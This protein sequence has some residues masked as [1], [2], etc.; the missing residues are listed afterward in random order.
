M[1]S[2][3]FFVYSLLLLFTPASAALG[4]GVDLRILP[5]GDS[6]T[7]GFKSSDGNGYRNDLLSK[8][9]G[10]NVRYIGSQRA[11][12]MANNQNDGYSGF[13]ISQ[14]ASQI[15]PA[16][17]QRPN[18]VLLMAGT[19]DINN[20]DNTGTAPNRLG[21]LLDQIISTCPDA[22]V[23]LA[24][25]TPIADG[26]AESRAR[27]FNSAIDTVAQS[28]INAGHKVV[29]VDMQNSRNGLTAGDLTDGLHP[30]NAGYAKMANVWWDGL[31][32]ASSKNLITAPVKGASL[33]GEAQCHGNLFWY[34]N[35]GTIA[36]GVGSSD[37]PFKSLWQPVGTVATGIGPGPGVRIADMDGDGIDDYVMV[38]AKTGAAELYINGGYSNG[39]INWISEGQIASGIGDGAGVRFADI[40]GDGKA[41]Y[42]WIGKDGSLTAYENGGPKSGGG[43]N[44]RPLNSITKG[45]DTGNRNSI[46]FA[47]L[48]GDGRA[49]FSI[50]GSGGSLKSWIATGR[51]PEP[52]WLPLGQTASGI[53]DLAGV[54][55]VDLNGDGRAD[56]VWLD[57]NSASY[58]YMNLRAKD[59]LVPSW[60]NAGQIGSG[61]GTGRE[62]ITFGDLT[63]DGKADFLVI[64]NGTGAIDMYVNN[65]KG[66]SYQAGDQVVFAD[67]D[68]D[69]LD[70]YISIGPNG[71]LLAY[72]NGGANSAAHNGWN[73]IN[74]GTIASG[75]AKREQIRYV[76]HPKAMKCIDLSI[77]IGRSQ[78]RW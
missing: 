33:G 31:N 2:L 20:N 73:W 40:T 62:N 63:G 28:R 21:A 32:I 44:F 59:S 19:N 13:E 46:I 78:W 52:K 77:Q 70:D 51:D 39:K 7:Y 53:G 74:W 17:S 15:A 5:V 61:V 42:I 4:N 18:I 69:G 16:L 8:F 22:V 60:I 41:D 50:V 26:A 56:Y 45:L 10:N 65:G 3:L 57:K 35:H 24:K 72:Q 34:N 1:R 58:A 25:I 29:V 68:G 30:T 55:L 76:D 64:H 48:D 54:H 43:W 23:V 36:S 75:V 49:D 27:T 11:G 6:I 38:D 9:S 66:A 71:A 37:G 67:L 12:N 47:D 14:I